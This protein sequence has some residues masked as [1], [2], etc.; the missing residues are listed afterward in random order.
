MISSP[1]GRSSR[2]PSQL[3]STKCLPFPRRWG[4][5]STLQLDT[6]NCGQDLFLSSPHECP[7]SWPCSQSGWANCS[8]LHELA[9]EVLPPTP[10]WRTGCPACPQ[11]HTTAS[12]LR[13]CTS[14]CR[15]RWLKARCR[16][17]CHLVSCVFWHLETNSPSPR[18]TS[19]SP[20]PLWHRPQPRY[21]FSENSAV[22]RSPPSV[23]TSSWEKPRPSLAPHLHL[24]WPCRPRESSGPRSSLGLSK[25]LELQRIEVGHHPSV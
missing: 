10:W 3:R 14:G 4:L 1:C 23:G 8:L 18:C 22:H 13:S 9:L 5:W 7:W 15:C 17:W 2:C 20:W 21:F 6:W 25:L 11:T 19:C 12:P 24:S 16:W